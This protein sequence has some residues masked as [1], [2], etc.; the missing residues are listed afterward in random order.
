MFFGKKNESGGNDFA[1]LMMMLKPV[2]KMKGINVDTMIPDAAATLQAAMLA[3]NL[4]I[5]AM[6]SVNDTGTGFDLG[7][8]LVAES[9]L[10]LI[11]K[12]EITSIDGAFSQF[13]N[14]SNTF[15]ALI[16]ATRNNTVQLIEQPGTNDTETTGGELEPGAAGTDGAAKSEPDPLDTSD[17]E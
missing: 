8:Y 4:T 16:D 9:G 17:A 2:L 7:F 12:E 13:S 14:I 3:A 1:P 6:V 10:N 11:H 15:K 5:V